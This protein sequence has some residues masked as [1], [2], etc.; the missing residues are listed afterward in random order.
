MCVYVCVCMC[1]YVCVLVCV[2]SWSVLLP[3]LGDNLE[4]FFQRVA[5]V[6]FE[7]VAKEGLDRS[8]QRE[9]VA[10]GSSLIG[11]LCVVVSEKE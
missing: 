1:V 10:V 4:N 11:R 6:T 7:R 8:K 5:C 3:L 2:L 9:T